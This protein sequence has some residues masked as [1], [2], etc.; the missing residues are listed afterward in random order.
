[1]E[2]VNHLPQMMS[3]IRRVLKPEGT[4]IHILPSPAWRFWTSVAHYFFMFKHLFRIKNS[5]YSLNSL[6]SI[7]EKLRSKGR[8]F[9]LT[10]IVMAG[11]HG[12]YPNALAE[13]FYFS[14]YSWKNVFSHNYFEIIKSSKT[15]LFYTGYEIFP[16]LSL[17]FRIKLSSVLGSACNIF[18]LKPKNKLVQ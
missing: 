15:K 7:E 17:N 10:R 4:A 2:H 5:S 18:I 3:E 1:M 9:L 8:L 14:R 13:L 16:K 12:E 6:P 11:P